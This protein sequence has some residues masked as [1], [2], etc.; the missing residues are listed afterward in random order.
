MQA[1]GN[2]FCILFKHIISSYPLP[3]FYVNHFHLGKK[4]TENGIK[5]AALSFYNATL[6]LPVMQISI[7]TDKL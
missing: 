2:G 1:L 7:S 6:T 5:Y 3:Y 4:L